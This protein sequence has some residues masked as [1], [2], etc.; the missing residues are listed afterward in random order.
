MATRE[1]RYLS[2]CGLVIIVLYLRI[3]SLCLLQYLLLLK[4]K[5]TLVFPYPCH[6]YKETNCKNI[7]D[8]YE[9]HE[10][11]PKYMLR[12]SCKAVNIAMTTNTPRIILIIQSPIIPEFLEAITSRRTTTLQFRL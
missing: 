11:T 4:T 1:Q 6:P 10:Y 8:Y 2:L 9:A 7:I 12:P 5:I 3:L